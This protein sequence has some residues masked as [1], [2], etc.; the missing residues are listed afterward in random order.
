MPKITIYFQK[1]FKVSVISTLH[2]KSGLL[3]VPLLYPSL[4]LVALL[5]VWSA[6][7][8]KPQWNQVCLS[9]CQVDFDNP[10]FDAEERKSEEY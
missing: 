4:L 3:P 7:V 2:F 10:L 1:N 5:T 8:G 9:S 6:P